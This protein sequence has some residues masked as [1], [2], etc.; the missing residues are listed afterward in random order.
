MDIQILTESIKKLEAS[1]HQPEIRK[2]VQ[3][4]NKLLADEFIEITKSGKVCTKSGII[5][6]LSNETSAEIKMSE[7]SLSVLAENIILVRYIA[8]QIPQK[9]H[10]VVVSRRSSIWKLFGDNW[11]MI[12]HQGTPIIE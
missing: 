6:A 5:N 12:F 1:L 8:H 7:F 11:K 3:I 9:V 10:P 2:D 4:L